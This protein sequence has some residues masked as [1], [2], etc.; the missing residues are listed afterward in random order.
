MKTFESTIQHRVKDYKVVRTTSAI[1][2]VIF[3]RPFG[4]GRIFTLPA[5]GACAVGCI[6]SPPCGLSFIPASAV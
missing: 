3:F 6:L 2:G 1:S 5:R 4:A